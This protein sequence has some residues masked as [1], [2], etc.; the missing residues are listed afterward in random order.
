GVG[1]LLPAGP[2]APPLPAHRGDEATLFD[3]PATQRELFPRLETEVGEFPQGLVEV[4]ADVRGSDFV[5]RDVAAQRDRGIPGK[6]LPLK[7]AS[8]QGR[9]FREEEYP[10]VK[11]HLLGQLGR[12]AVFEAFE[13]GQSGSG[14]PKD[15]WTGGW[16]QVDLLCPDR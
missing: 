5:G 6:V 8:D 10:A 11:P 4:V 12:G 3:R 7:L 14:K 15:D 2:L 1:R 13:H 9:V 16:D